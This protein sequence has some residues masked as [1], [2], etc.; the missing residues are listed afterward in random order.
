[1]ACFFFY[2]TLCN[3]AL[4]QR[5]L[6]RPVQ[7]QPAALANHA[8]FWAKDGPYPVIRACAGAKAEGLLIDGLTPAD[9]AR[10][11]FYEGGFGFRKQEVQVHAAGRDV[12]ALVYFPDEG[13]AGSGAVWSL[14][15]WDTRYGDA[16]LATAGDFMSL[17][18][19]VPAAKVAARYTAMLVRGASAVRAKSPSVPT[20]RRAA[21]PDDVHV[22]TRRL[23]YAKFFAVEEWEVAW[24]QFDGSMNMP[25]ERAVFVSCD[26]VTVLPYDPARDR[27]LLIEQFRAGPMA[28]GDA[29]AW[30]LEAIAGR[31]DAGETPEQ[32]GRREAVEEAGLTLGTLLPVAQYYPSPGIMSEFLY[33]YVGLADLPDG[34]AGV[35][36]QTDEAEDIRG[37]LISFDRMMELVASGEIANSPLILTALWLQRER[38]RLLVEAAPSV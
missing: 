14:S 18:G 28:R 32:A 1:M 10:L 33:S 5:V 3:E 20:L 9:V 35:F 7:G 38:A 25:V 21:Q 12:S 24:R 23:A 31:I 30:Q 26:A 27:V 22:T 16:V 37:H 36:G 4:L 6:G 2:G 29:G 34:I 19:Q 8:V 13:Q 11:D 15:D 17:M